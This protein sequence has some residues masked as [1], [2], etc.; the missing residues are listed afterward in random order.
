M[1]KGKYYIK[2][3]V[4]D[5]RKL[6]NGRLVDDLKFYFTDDLTS[7]F[8]D[9]EGAFCCWRYFYIYKMPN[10]FS[11]VGYFSR[12][13]SHFSALEKEDFESLPIPKKGKY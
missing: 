10:K 11:P 13:Y 4:S 8:N 6:V 1:K 5:R 2:A 9:L 7:I 12:S 3:N